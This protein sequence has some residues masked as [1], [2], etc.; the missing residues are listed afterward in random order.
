MNDL[1]SIIVYIASKLEDSTTIL[2]V[3]GW[4]ETEN[5]LDLIETTLEACIPG[6]WD[7]MEAGGFPET[8]PGVPIGELENSFKGIQ[9]RLL[10]SFHK[11]L[12]KESRLVLTT[13]PEWKK[14]QANWFAVFAHFK[15]AFR[16]SEEEMPMARMMASRALYKIKQ[17]QDEPVP[18]FIFRVTVRAAMVAR[19]GDSPELEV[20]QGV[21]ADGLLP[22]YA[23]AA[24]DLLDVENQRLPM[25]RWAKFITAR[26]DPEPPAQLAY[27]VRP[28]SVKQCQF[29]SAKIEGEMSLHCALH[30]EP[31][32]AIRNK[33]KAK[34]PNPKFSP[35]VSTGTVS[36]KF[37]PKSKKSS[38]DE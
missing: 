22:R 5:F 7:V 10:L 15:K 17:S 33:H 38:K 3:P 21:V 28:E 4:F 6:L 8:E 24:N 36:S 30:C 20:I 25:A 14:I 13:P 12:S 16:P 26:E 32:L 19:F 34:A 1:M 18:D 2:H 27:V 35:S 23:R 37:S 9:S 31:L 29:C 11:A